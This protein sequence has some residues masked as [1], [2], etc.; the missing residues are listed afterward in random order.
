M[1]QRAK[2]EAGR[3]EQAKARI[4]AV[5]QAMKQAATPVHAGSAAAHATLQLLVLLKSGA[6]FLARRQTAKSGARYTS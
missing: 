6:Q 3:A 5:Q 2:L 4:G 1:I